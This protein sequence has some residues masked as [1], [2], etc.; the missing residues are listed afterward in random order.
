M[1]KERSTQTLSAKADRSSEGTASHLLYP[2]WQ[3]EEV[4]EN[5]L[6][7][8]FLGSESRRGHPEAG[9]CFDMGYG[10]VRGYPEQVEL[11][12]EW[13]DGSAVSWQFRVNPGTR[14]VECS[15][16]GTKLRHRLWVYLRD[17]QVRVVT[18]S[19][20][21]WNPFSVGDVTEVHYI[22]MAEL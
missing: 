7:V 5:M 10:K 15:V 9:T 22:D 1:K 20:G 17:G 2:Y 12:S 13:F 14:Q 4:P 21:L 6:L 19:P 11:P 8:M 18:M 16:V 3:F